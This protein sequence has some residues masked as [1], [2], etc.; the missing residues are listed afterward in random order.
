MVGP[1]QA[2]GQGGMEVGEEVVRDNEGEVPGPV[3][4]RETRIPLTRGLAE[5]VDRVR[6]EAV[7]V[8]DVRG[9]GRV[10]MVL[11]PGVAPG[12]LVVPPPE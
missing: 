9:R 3:I 10:G 1:G 12:H 11:L 7:Q 2:F 5:R 6:L 4:S 8:P